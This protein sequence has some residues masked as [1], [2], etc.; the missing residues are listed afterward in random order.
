MRLTEEKE[1]RSSSLSNPSAGM[2]GGASSQEVAEL[3]VIRKRANK[4][5]KIE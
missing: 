5:D 1:L 2:G 3:Q 4:K